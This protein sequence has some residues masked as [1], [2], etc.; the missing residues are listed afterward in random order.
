MTERRADNGQFELSVIVPAYEEAATIAEALRRLD[1]ELQRQPLRY[2]VIVVSDGCTD[3]TPEI[4]RELGLPNQRVVHYARNQ[5][6]GYAIRTGGALAEGRLVAFIDG[7]LDIHPSSLITLI[8]QL[9]RTD[10]DAV[11]A[12]KVHP[13]SSVHYPAF[14][15]LQSSVFRLAVRTLFSLDV[16]DSQTG[17]KVFRADLVKE[18]LPKVE[19]S[20]FAFDLELLVLANDAGYKVAEGPVELDYQ[21]STTTGV[22]AVMQMLRDLAAIRGRRRRASRPR[23]TRRRHKAADVD[24]MRLVKSD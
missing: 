11:V 15:R 21:F 1:G 14:R 16:A 4:A 12:S 19:S 23:P 20:G 6:K 22:S 3:G 5:G 10:V 24:H 7:D 8:D 18:C 13:D 9:E 17:L 2:E